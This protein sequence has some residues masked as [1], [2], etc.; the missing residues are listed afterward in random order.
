M[1][2]AARDL[3]TDIDGMPT[4]D[5]IFDRRPVPRPLPSS[6]VVLALAIAVL[7][8]I[9]DDIEAD[10]IEHLALEIVNR[11]EELL[12]VRALL[13]AALEQ[14][15]L[16]IGEHDRIRDQHHRVLDQ[17]RTLRAQTMSKPEAA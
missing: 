11:D 14:L 17:Y 9:A 7:P 3:D 16:D 10:L 12:A 13:A 6:D 8:T 15:Q 4:A 5:E 2:A 1:T